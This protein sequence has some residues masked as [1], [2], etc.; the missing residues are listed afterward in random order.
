MNQFALKYTYIDFWRYILNETVCCSVPLYSYIVVA[1]YTRACVHTQG[2]VGVCV[3]RQRCMC[4][5]RCIVIAISIPRA[6]H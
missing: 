1:I 4:V 3:F 6:R 2:K 5:F